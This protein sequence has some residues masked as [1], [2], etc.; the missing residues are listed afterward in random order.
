MCFFLVR[1]HVAT[2]ASVC[3]VFES[4]LRYLVFRNE[5]DGVGSSHSAVFESLG[6]SAEFVGG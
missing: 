3:D 4:V 1:F 6:E 2:K 5:K